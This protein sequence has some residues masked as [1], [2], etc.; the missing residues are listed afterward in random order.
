MAEANFSITDEFNNVKSVLEGDF[1]KRNTKF[2][3]IFD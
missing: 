2:N 3:L 1:K